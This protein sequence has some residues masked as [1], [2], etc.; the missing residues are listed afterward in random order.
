MF[1]WSRQA[2]VVVLGSSGLSVVLQKRRLHFYLRVDQGVL[3]FGCPDTLLLLL[4]QNLPINAYHYPEPA[5]VMLRSEVNQ[6]T[7]GVD[8]S[9]STCLLG[10]D[11]DGVT[12]QFCKMFILNVKADGEDARYSGTKKREYQLCPGR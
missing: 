7:L 11:R 4:L 5:S 10:M 9:N 12:R 8:K 1:L 6:Q 3:L 2:L